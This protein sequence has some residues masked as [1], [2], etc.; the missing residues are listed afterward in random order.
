M[1]PDND[2]KMKLRGK[3]IFDDMRKHFNLTDADE[4]SL[5]AKWRWNLFKKGHII[6]GQNEILQNIAY[7]NTGLAR[8]FYIENGR[9]HNFSF[10]F[11][12]H[13]I[14]K[15]QQLV[16]NEKFRLFVQ[17]LDDSEVCYI[18]MQTLAT[19]TNRATGEMLKFINMGLLKHVAFLEEQMFMLRMPA[20][21]RYE[22]VVRKYPRL[23]EAVSI[24][25]LASYLNL[26]KETLYRIR[27]GK[28]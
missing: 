16:E 7:L 27:S 15:P 28:Y 19:L 20:T 24:T 17:F 10:T 6:D 25:Q 22:W 11:E 3:E 14:L 9:E 13:F 23:V 1:Q 18:P 12:A 8:T 4:R 21:D 5:R 26:T 2:I